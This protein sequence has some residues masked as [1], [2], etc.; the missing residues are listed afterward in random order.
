[1]V[2]R[3]F[4]LGDVALDAT[5]GEDWNAD[6]RLE[7]KDSVRLAECLANVTVA[8]VHGD[9]GVALTLGRRERLSSGFLSIEGCVKI[10]TS[11]EGG[12]ECVLESRRIDI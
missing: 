11:M 12:S 8:A 9:Y 10:A 1:M 7:C 2:Q 4:A 6:S 3:G 5:P